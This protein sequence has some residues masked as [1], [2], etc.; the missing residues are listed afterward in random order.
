MPLKNTY[1]FPANPRAPMEVAQKERTDRVAQKD[2]LKYTALSEWLRS[3]MFT[4]TESV[5]LLTFWGFIMFFSGNPCSSSQELLGNV[6][7]P[8]PCI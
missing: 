8:T 3:E 7:H 4:G 6:L 1:A 2:L 5:T